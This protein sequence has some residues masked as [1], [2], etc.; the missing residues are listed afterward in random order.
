MDADPMPLPEFLDQGIDEL[1]QL[2]FRLWQPAIRNWEAPKPNA[3]LLAKH[4]LLLQAQFGN[5]VILQ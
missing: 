2:V 3:G 4:N 5:L 1:R